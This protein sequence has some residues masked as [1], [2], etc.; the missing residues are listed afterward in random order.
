M[1]AS[2]AGFTPA[3]VTTENSVSARKSTDVVSVSVLARLATNTPMS[4]VPQASLRCSVC[5]NSS[6]TCLT[7]ELEVVAAV[8]AGLEEVAWLEVA[9]LEVAGLVDV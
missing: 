3:C 9:G 5:C 1:A 8:V 7:T 4:G 2:L 6:W